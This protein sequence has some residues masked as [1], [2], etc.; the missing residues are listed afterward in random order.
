[1]LVGRLK[2]VLLGILDSLQYC[3]RS[4]I[5]RANADAVEVKLGELSNAI[6]TTLPQV[7]QRALERFFDDVRQ[8]IR[9]QGM[10]PQAQE[11]R[12]R[13]VGL[14]RDRASQVVSVLTTEPVKGNI[15]AASQGD[16]R[17]V[18]QAI[19]GVLGALEIAKLDKVQVELKPAVVVTSNVREGRVLHIELAKLCGVVSLQPDRVAGRHV[20]RGLFEGVWG[21]R[22]VYLA[23]MSDV[24]LPAALSAFLELY[25]SLK[26][27]IVL[28]VG[29][30]GGLPERSSTLKEGVVVIPRFVFEY[31]RQEITGD[32][33][34]YQMPPYR[35]SR[36][37]L[38]L[39]RNID[40]ANG[41]GE[42][43]IIANKDYASGSA[44]IDSTKSQLR[45][46]IIDK[47]PVDV[48]AV[49]MEAHAMLHAAWELGSKQGDLIVGVVKSVSDVSSGD[50]EANKEVRQLSAIQNAARVAI[51]ILKEL[52]DA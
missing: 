20:R 38:E 42:L 4:G 1:M 28:A 9:I 37:F 2:G 51:A 12:N 3:A 33:I 19:A 6:A 46:D 41:F 40:I 18:S 11:G 14:F 13:L 17:R 50:A 25:G 32:G 29:C 52:D 24:A 39:V 47:F 44:F 8:W 30:C 23:P 21:R 49:E 15:S 16:V 26:P 5:K 43:T 48:I 35:T 10:D 22:P 45:Q 27:R 34:G 36:E 7:D 31:D